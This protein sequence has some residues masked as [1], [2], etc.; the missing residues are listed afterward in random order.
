MM[1]VK[2]LKTVC[3]LFGFLCLLAKGDEP[4]GFDFVWTEAADVTKE[5]NSAVRIAVI[6]D[7]QSGVVSGTLDDGDLWVTN[8]EG[9]YSEVV[10]VEWSDFIP[11]PDGEDDPSSRTMAV[12]ELPAPEGG[13]TEDFN[14]EYAIMLAGEEVAKMD[15]T[16]FELALAGTFEVLIGGVT[17]TVPALSGGISVATFATPGAPGGNVSELA[18]ATM[19]VTFPHPVEVNWGEVSRNDDGVFCVEVEGYDLGGIV[20]EVLTSYTHRVELGMLEPGDHTAALKE[21][22]RELARSGFQVA[23]GSDHLEKGLPSRV[24]IELEKLPTRSLFPVFAANIRLTFGQYVE[25]V[26]WTEAS[27]KG[28]LSSSSFTAWIDSRVLLVTPMV[29]EHQVHLGMFPPG[30]Y[31]YLLNSLEEMVGSVP[32]VVRDPSG[33]VKAPEVTVRDAKVI[34]PGEAALEFTVEYSDRGELVVE[35]IEAQALTAVNRMGEVFELERTSLNFT[36]DVAAGAIATYRMLPPDGSWDASDRGRYRLLLSEPELVC[37]RFG[38]HLDSPLIGY[39]SVEIEP[40][41]PE[42]DHTTGLTIVNDELIGRWTAS[43]RL[44]VPEDLA[45]RDDWSVTWGE[46]RAA[47]PAFFLRP[48][49]VRAGS[50]EEIGRIPPSDTLGAGIWVQHDYD[51]GPVSGGRWLVCLS[52]NLGHFAK[53]SMTAGIPG[54]ANIQENSFDAWSD[55]A[56]RELDV[57]ENHR[58]WE[59]S[60]GTDPFDPGDD[61]LGDPKP[62]LIDGEDGKKHLGLRCRIATSAVD[63][64]LRFEGSSDMSTWASLGRDQIEEVERTGGDD[65]IEEFVVCLVEDLQSSGIRYLRVVAERW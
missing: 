41:D 2:L 7:S 27:R 47:G 64:R 12:Y 52:S 38:N 32:I 19:T 11:R 21:G 56:N 59:Y 65:G 15:D 24:E 57:S 54:G 36:A 35:G 49:F 18:I 30:E 61:H 50:N 48:R 23:G 55:W 3:I 9:F 13:W 33:D 17:Q 39:V 45:V 53:E 62:E 31:R 26:E 6:F 42:P 16:Y 46:V 20:P 22:N 5:G 43:V 34:A 37:D 1:K 14:G 63:A 51:L 40:D 4:L 44:F 29:V 58:I 25:R 8:S 10:F 28:N 60:V